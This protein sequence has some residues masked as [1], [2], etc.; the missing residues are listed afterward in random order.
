[1]LERA[2]ICLDS[3]RRHLLRNPNGVIRSRRLLKPHFWRHSVPDSKNPSW[4]ISFW[5]T[6]PLMQSES[7]NVVEKSP[8]LVENT[9]HAFLEFLYPPPC[10]RFAMSWLSR[11]RSRLPSRRKR[12]IIPNVSRPYV[13][14][15][16]ELCEAPQTK[17][18]SE[19]PSNSTDQENRTQKVMT[20]HAFLNEKSK[21][22][23]DKAWELFEEAGNP[24]EF[25]SRLLDYLRTSNR[26]V[27]LKRAKRLFDTIDLEMRTADDYLHVTTCLL[28][29]GRN[30]D[31]KHVCAEAMARCLGI[32][33]WGTAFASFV[34]SSQWQNMAEL[35]DFRPSGIE[36]NVFH[37]ALG[38]L[39][40]LIDLPDR[41]LRLSEYLKE[42]KSSSV[43]SKLGELAPF[44]LNLLFRTPKMMKA[45]STEMILR[46]TQNFNQLELLTS[47]HYHYAIEVLQSFEVRSDIIRSMVVY[48]NFRWHMDGEVPPQRLLQSLLKTLKS[49]EITHGIQYILKEYI[50]FYGKPSKEAY[51]LALATFSRAGDARSVGDLFNNLVA[52]HGNPQSLRWI[53]PC[54]YVHARLGRV[55]ETV[56]EFRKISEEF[57][58]L[59]NIVCWNILLTAYANAK[60][61]SGAFST[62]EEM[63]G[64]NVRP[65]PYTFGI[66]MSL[67][68]NRGDIN[69]VRHLFQVARKLQVKITTAMVDTIIEAYCN[70]QKFQDA[71]EIAE[72]C[73]SLDMEG[74]RVRMW[75]I[76]LWMHA[77][78]GDLDSVS[79]IQSR[80]ES[81][82]LRPDQMTYAALILS[83][84]LVRRPD[85]ARRILRTLHRSRRVHAIELHYIIILYAYVQAR[86]RD[87]VQVLYREM[88]ERFNNPSPSARLLMLKNYLMKDLQLLKEEGYDKRDDANV[89]LVSA[90]RFL[91]DTLA[92]FDIKQL[93][94]KQPQPGT[95]R[96]SL[97][98]AFPT[99]YYQYIIRAYGTAGA[100]TKV[101][102]L[103]DRFS[104]NGQISVSN[105]SFNEAPPIHLLAALMHAHLK[106]EQYSKVEE[107]WR[108]ALPRAVKLASRLDVETLMSSN[109]PTDGD[110]GHPNPPN[111]SVDILEPKLNSSAAGAA[112][113]ILPTQRFILWKCISLYMQA[114]AF[115]GEPWR[116]PQLVAEF[117]GLG[118][119]L[120]THNWSTYVQML[121]MSKRATDQMEAFVTFEEKFMPNF[122]GWQNLRL[123]LAVKPEG[124]PDTLDCI[125]NPKRGKRRGFLGKAGRR[126]WSKIQPD[127]MMPTYTTMV[128]LASALLDFRERS[129]IDGGIQLKSL[130]ASAPKTIQTIA[131]MPR[132]REKFQG[133]F[134]RRR[135]ELGD[136]EMEP[137]EPFVWTGGILGVGGESRT[138]T[139]PKDELSKLSETG[140]LSVTAAP[141][142]VSGRPRQE[143]VDCMPTSQPLSAAGMI[144]DL[145]YFEDASLNYVDDLIGPP[146]RT[147]D[148][149]DQ[150]DI[151]AETLL[152]SRQRLLGIDPLTEEEPPD[153]DGWRL[154]VGL[155]KSKAPSPESAAKDSSP[156]ESPVASRK[157]KGPD[158]YS[159]MSESA[160]EE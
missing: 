56:K 62:W 103:F 158:I 151:E 43:D 19:T 32:S 100:Y 57:G 115:Q 93:A 121:A 96:Q 16:S 11:P 117:Q 23:H 25:R 1:M 113:S 148:Y 29:S 150:V 131:D 97:R 140:A 153:V 83:L 64:E 154:A 42:Q 88:M 36:Y 85:S 91:A 18:S 44:L 90:E 6:P 95:A 82:G 3:A 22:E 71:E 34:Q 77:F 104:Q 26:P 7:L 72:A 92:E 20:L 76:L 84:A 126:L 122:P 86:N 109:C 139:D 146:E 105:R 81:A 60:D 129:I 87:M 112:T 28:L 142:E 10:Q 15:A 80:M 27:D 132:L 51:K 55:E 9:T 89:R 101:Q 48:R 107:C 79:R 124:A 39:K 63:V 127:F 24:P 152:Q 30:A 68:A 13:S 40:S 4:R 75:N 65:N 133:I 35:W 49:L 155:V 119:S 52:D 135:E 61:I 141:S 41:I 98:E 114:L 78:R 31:V 134:L 136:K 108:M 143:Q 12:R 5:Y 58:L 116:I 37:D 145:E 102:G 111:D 8:H 110:Q 70:N 123:G 53:T 33:S 45:I 128:Y 21:L 50:L 67:C 144:G 125:E 94:S 138:V 159:I 137:H 2:A 14:E 66:L 156:N 160:A 17:L 47:E 118:F 147:L 149:Q 69:A 73:L 46:L 59:P 54:L 130:F 38:F 120:T 74:S 157:V 106:T 99:M